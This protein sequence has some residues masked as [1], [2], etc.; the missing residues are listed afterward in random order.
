M[1]I[2]KSKRSKTYFP[3]KT[4][5]V[6]KSLRHKFKFI[7]YQLQKQSVQ[8]KQSVDVNYYNFFLFFVFSACKLKTKEEE[9][10]ISTK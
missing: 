5:Q 2:I 4:Y 10:K 9:E 1:K 6:T 7:P 3:N 8:V